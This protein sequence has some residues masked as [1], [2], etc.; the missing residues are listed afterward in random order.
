MR[1][2][3]LSVENDGVYGAY[4]PNEQQSKDT[5][6]LMLGDSIDDRLTRSGVKWVNEQGC[7]SFTM[8]PSKG[9]Y[10]YHNFPL[11]HFDIVIKFLQKQGTRRIGI[12]GASTTGMLALIVA[13]YYSDITLT[14]AMSPS[15]FV[16]EGFYQGKKDQAR[17]WPGN[18][19]STVSMDG[20]PLP[21]LPFAYRHPDYW[22]KIKEESRT[23]KDIIASRKMFEESEKLHPVHEVERIKV[24]RMKGQV[25]FIGAEDDALWDTVKYIKRMDEILKNKPHTCSYHT[26]T[27]E[28]GTHFVFPQSMVMN[29]LP[30]FGN[31]L[32][33]VFKSGRAHPKEC[34]AARIDIDKKIRSAISYW[35][36]QDISNL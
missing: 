1:R 12:I 16:M 8:S 5:M 35:K 34:K 25:L 15:D 31:L 3:Y 9:N 21:Y 10:G 30:V 7:N 27:Y 28:F 18:N 22:Q 11:E 36:I 29:V 23:G 26:M 17:E 20:K 33:R 32:S 6:I 13:S 24:E 14:I 4:W 19:E 2:T